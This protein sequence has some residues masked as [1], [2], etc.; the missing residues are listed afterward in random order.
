[1]QEPES[2]SWL[3]TETKTALQKVP[4]LKI[5]PPTTDTFAVVVLSRGAPDNHAR[6]VRAFDRVLHTS[7]VDAERQTTLT[8]PF[9]V[10]RGLAL[11]DAMLA[12]FELICCDVISIF[13]SDDVVSHAEASYLSGLYRNVL[14][15]DEF[16]SL[17]VRVLFIPDSPAGQA[18]TEQFVGSPVEHFPIEMVVMRK[19][20]R[21]MAHWAA[22]I[23]ANV[24]TVLD[25]GGR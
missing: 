24:D 17:S 1:M 22:K 14:H 7:P 10:K 15:A 21:I 23:G 8:P 3:D 11:S 5:A 16:Q 19:K 4:P 13:L 12:Q 9:V 25:A 6:L 18:F 2:H 20:A